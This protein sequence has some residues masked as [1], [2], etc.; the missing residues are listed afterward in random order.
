MKPPSMRASIPETGPPPIKDVAGKVAFITGGSSGIGL[1]IARAYAMAGTKVVLGYRTQAHADEAMLHF[2]GAS[3][4]VHA[5]RVDVTD[6]HAMEQA[7]LEVVRMLGKVHVLVNNAGVQSPAP[8]STM[9]YEEW[10]RLMSVNLGGIFNGI[11][12][13][14]PHIEQ[15]GEGGH[16]I[17]TASILGLFTP[18]AGYGAYCASRFAAVALMESLRAELHGS[19]I[20]VSV[21]C[22]GLVKSNLEAS[23]K[24]SSAAS[25]PLEIGRLVLRGMQNNDLYI[26][27]HPEFNPIIQSRNDAILA[28]TPNDLHPSDERHA[29]ASS[30]LQSSLY[31]KQ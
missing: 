11:R 15:H 4:C 1:G 24:D 10:D 3:D 7:A 12:A 23:L 5:L 25:D 14:L 27:T 29:L 18:G 22:P 20:G 17:T 8:L 31:F 30:I 21:V 28:S 13:F 2:S 16:V 9:S 6:R 26:L 19:N